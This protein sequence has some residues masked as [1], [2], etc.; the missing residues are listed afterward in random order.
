MEQV[1]YALIAKERTFFTDEGCTEDHE[2]EWCSRP[3]YGL[4]VTPVTLHRYRRDFPLIGYELARG[5]E[6]EIGSSAYVIVVEYTQSDTFGSSGYWRVDS[7]LSDPHKA[8]ER[9]AALH[10]EPEWDSWGV[11]LDSVEIYPMVVLR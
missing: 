8:S 9:A 4:S 10:D 3:S 7:V 5:E 2:H 6:V 11:S 1:D